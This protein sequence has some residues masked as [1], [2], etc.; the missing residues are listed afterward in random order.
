[1]R[2]IAGVGIRRL[3]LRRRDEGLMVDMATVVGPAVSGP[4]RGAGGGGS[5]LTSQLPA[6]TKFGPGILFRVVGY[7][8]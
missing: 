6:S 3:H 8:N 4:S 5:A 1:M 7:E 2:G